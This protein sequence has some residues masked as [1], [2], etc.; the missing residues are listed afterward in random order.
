VDGKKKEDEYTPDKTDFDIIDELRKDGRISYRN[1]AERL[2]ISDGTVRFRVGR[3]IDQEIIKISALI[4]PFF[5]ENSILAL[6]GMELESRTHHETMKKISQ[7]ERVISVCNTAGQYDLFV[8]VFCRSRK[9]LNAFLFEELPKIEGI[10]STHTYVY[11][12]AK[13]KWVDAE[14]TP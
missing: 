3:L 11:L 12:E 6:I 5:F 9:E 10:K 7:M 14:I 8:E 1:I 2:G 13:N 4:N